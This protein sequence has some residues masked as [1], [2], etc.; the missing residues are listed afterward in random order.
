MTHATTNLRAPPSPRNDLNQYV[1]QEP[2]RFLRWTALCCRVQTPRILPRSL[3]HLLCRHIFSASLQKCLAP[4]AGESNT[5]GEVQ[6]RSLSYSPIY[7]YIYLYGGASAARLGGA[8]AARLGRPVYGTLWRVW[9]R[10]AE[11]P[12]LLWEQKWKVHDDPSGGF[13]FVAPLICESDQWN[14]LL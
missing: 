14:A 5:R 10:R 6:I 3:E 11:R 7:I 1:C 8:S 9:R 4:S 12:H 13:T 2:R